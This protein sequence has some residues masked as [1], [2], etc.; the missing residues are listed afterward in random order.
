MIKTMRLKRTFEQLEAQLRSLV[1]KRWTASL[2]TRLFFAG[3]GEQVQ[4]AL[5][6]NAQHPSAT[7]WVCI[8][9]AQ[10][11]FAQFLNSDRLILEQLG[12]AVQKMATEMG[13]THITVE[14]VKVQQDET[15][16]PEVL[17]LKLHPILDGSF[18]GTVDV[19]VPETGSVP[20]GA[21]LIVDGT[22]VFPLERSV[23]NIGRRLDNQLVIEDGRVSRLHAQ[24]RAVQGEYIILDLDSKGGT[25][26]NGERIHQKRLVPGDVISLAGVP[27]VY[28]QNPA[29]EE[30]TQ[31]LR[32][33]E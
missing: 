17:R 14:E 2:D 6:E 33:E 29:H 4:Q 9:I 13:Y 3:L 26:V 24:M 19:D 18:T 20:R 16:H 28:G 31:E 1:E 23:T 10:P 22:R 27:L 12:Q 25:W 5:Q 11:Q 15:L 8:L 30:E 21:Y 7:S 32:I